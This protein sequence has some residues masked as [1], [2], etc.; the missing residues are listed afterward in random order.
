LTAEQRANF[1]CYLAGHPV[2]EAFCAAKQRLAT[3]LLIKTANG[4]YAQK[5]LQKLLAQ[6]GQFASS[7]AKSLGNTLMSWLEPIVRMWRFSISNGI[8]EDFHTKME[9][10]SRRA[11]G[12]RNF[13]N[14]RLR[15]LAHYGWNGVINRVL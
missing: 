10:L 2:L 13:E 11:F 5:Q 1:G 12:F 15:V 9:M 7:P 4:R 8:T 3:L 14:Y 6:L